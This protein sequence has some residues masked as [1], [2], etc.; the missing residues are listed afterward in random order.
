MTEETRVCSKCGETKPLSEFSKDRNR[1]KTHCKKC[2]CEKTK[3]IYHKDIDMSRMKARNRY[4]NDENRQD[5]LMYLR[6]Y[7]NN[8]IE[9]VMFK[10]AKRR[11]LQKGLDF[12]ITIDDIV[13]PDV[14]PVLGV[15]IFR[16]DGR[17]CDNSPSLDKIIPEKGYVKG[18]VRVISFRANSL[19]SNAT[20][21][22]VRKILEYME[23]EASH[24]LT[25]SGE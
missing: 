10:D 22:E 14:C 12:N 25:E 8:N 2:I 15:P 3:N 7:R 9:I 16:G 4:K 11:A 13:I 5:K 6:R 23:R 21:E 18:N 20:L 17:P 1:L 24:T 19:K